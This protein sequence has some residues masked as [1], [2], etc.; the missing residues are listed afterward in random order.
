M[1]AKPGLA[2]FL[3]LSLALLAAASANAENEL[4]ATFFKEADAAKVAA[5]AVDAKLLAPRSYERGMKE[6]RDAETALERGRNIET[7]RSNAADAANY[8]KTAAKAAALA[9]TALA[10]VMKS[11]QDA[12]NARAPELSAEIW[13]QAQRKFGEAIRLLE[14]G[15]LKGAKRRDIEA[16][17]LYREAELDAIKKQYLSETRQLL[18]DADRARVGRYA[19]LTLGKAKQL[20]ADA[21][22]ELSENRY[23]TDLPRSLA[24]QANYEAKHAIYLSEIVR[25]VRD[26]KLSTEQLVLNW[27][28][29][30]RA[31]SGVADVVP[32]MQDGPDRL[33]A[34][35]VAYFQAQ[36]N[37]LQALQQ[38]K[39]DNEVRIADM[40][41]EL[42]ALDERLG[43][44]TAER[45]ALV[46]R[47]EAQA[48]VKQQF[49]QVEKMFA[50]SEARVFRQGNSIILRLVGLSF[51]SGASQIKPENF[52]L[53][54]KVEKAIDVFPRSEITIEGHTDS[55]GGDDSN[56][57][58]S[59]ERAESV[60]Q[61]MINAMR[62]PTYRL[63]GT[64]F[65]ET[66]PVASNE[67]ESGRARNRRIDI[68]IKPSNENN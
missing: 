25:L 58:L 48:R 3:L 22:R 9:D 42:R 27:E 51:D 46:Q 6:Y 56:Q 45:A 63:I 2:K 1:V 68:V 52:D 26:K 5:D 47:L 32:D 29:P 66:R 19:P 37:E 64:G 34:E 41:E 43:G 33:A 14:R 49:E 7:V 61:Y 57:K 55:H 8:F 35:L 50:A 20:L 10:Q 62:I 38:E 39:S 12:A 18:D 31:V 11:R 65:G 17:T 21:E 28:Q 59:Q 30:L 4:R 16:T 15:D 54:G 36:A 40:E 53:L 13:T 60:Q 44:A 24:K 23:D 67:T